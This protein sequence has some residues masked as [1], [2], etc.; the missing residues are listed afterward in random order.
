MIVAI[1]NFDQSFDGDGQGFGDA[2]HVEG[3]DF[4]IV[5]LRDAAKVL[6]IEERRK[7]P[8]EAIVA[9]EK[10]LNERRRV[11]DTIVFD[12]KQRMASRE[13]AFGTL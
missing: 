8:P 3:E 10:P 5:V 4:S 2:E 1:E 11:F 12:V 7:M 13:D 6:R 9:I